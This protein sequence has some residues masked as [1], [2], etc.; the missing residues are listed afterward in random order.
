MSDEYS[1]Y[2]DNKGTVISIVGKGFAIIGAD[3]RMS[4]GYSI[5][6]RNV[7]KLSPLTDKICLG[8]GGQLADRIALRKLL[9]I[10]VKEYERKNH[11]VI[12]PNAFAQ[13]LSNTLYNRRFFPFYTFNMAVGVQDGESFLYDYDSIGSKSR[14]QYKVEGSG[15]FLCLPLMD[16]MFSNLTAEEMPELEEAVSIMRTL[17]G[18]VAERD[19]HTGD[20]IEM[21]IITDEGSEIREFD[22]RLD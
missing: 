2:T 6:S 3:T 16:E 13:L 4:D 21:C 9:K 8:S 10:R 19:I 17:F 12:N 14:H 20:K 5:P 22:L 18:S 15:V 11:E 7:T 1:P